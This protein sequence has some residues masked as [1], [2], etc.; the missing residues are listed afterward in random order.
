M[1]GRA[2]YLVSVPQDAIKLECDGCPEV[3]QSQAPRQ[4]SNLSKRARLRRLQ[5]SLKEKLTCPCSKVTIRII[6]L[7]LSLWQLADI[8]SDGVNT[9][10]YLHYARVSIP[11]P[12]IRQH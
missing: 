8:I 11:L 9:M 3:P 2:Y 5:S 7:A 4:L 6:K 10:M 1:S 12:I